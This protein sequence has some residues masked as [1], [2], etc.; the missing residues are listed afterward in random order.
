LAPCSRPSAWREA[1]TEPRGWVQMGT[2]IYIGR[3]ILFGL[4]PQLIAVSLVAFFL[5]RMLPGDAAGVLLGPNA[6][7]DAIAALRKSMGL[8]DPV[9][10]QYLHYLRGLLHGDLGRSWYSR[11]LVLHDL[12]ERA[13]ATLEL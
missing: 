8:E 5:L 13:P 9:Y 11:E 7:K 6:T 4:L 1:G 2:L 10:L 12:A 3:R